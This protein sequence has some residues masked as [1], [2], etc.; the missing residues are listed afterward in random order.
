[1]MEMVDV[2]GETLDG[3]PPSSTALH[4]LYDILPVDMD[5]LPQRPLRERCPFAT[6]E[7]GI[8]VEVSSRC[9]PIEVIRGDWMCDFE[10]VPDG[11]ER[12]VVDGDGRARGGHVG[13]GRA[14][15]L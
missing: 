7:G 10:D 9:P 13:M 4:K 5:E 12:Q 2:H 3:V 1:M 6:D 8:E 14:G 11:L 15:R